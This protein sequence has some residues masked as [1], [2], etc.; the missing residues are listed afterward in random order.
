MLLHGGGGNRQEWHAAGYVRRI[1][2]FFTVITADL[3]GH[4]ESGLP[5]DPADYTTHKMGQGQASLAR[6]RTG[7]FSLPDVMARRFRGPACDGQPQGIR[8]LSKR[9]QGSIPYG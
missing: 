7:R 5:T 3:R 6:H 9:V 4:G 8:G 1:Q 2:D